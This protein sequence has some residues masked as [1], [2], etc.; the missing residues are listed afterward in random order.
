MVLLVHL[1][2]KLPNDL[3]R[4]LGLAQRH[5]LHGRA[6]VLRTAARRRHG[7]DAAAEEI[8]HAVEDER[9]VVN[10]VELDAEETER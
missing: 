8:L 5:Y 7:L 1:I 6:A 2:E 9:G 10:G 3:H 4:D